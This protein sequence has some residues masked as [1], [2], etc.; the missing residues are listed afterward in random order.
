MFFF[1]S[2]CPLCK[3]KGQKVNSETM[4]H[5]VKDISKISDATYFY[6]STPSCDIVYFNNTEIFNTSMI[7]KEVGLKDSSSQQ[8]LV[9][10]CY[11]YAKSSL[12]TIGLSEKI[13]IRMNNYGSRCDTRHPA[14]ECCL[15]QIKQIVQEKLISKEKKKKSIRED[16]LR[17]KEKQALE[18]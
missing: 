11:N 17:L 2:K 12:D 16:M 5:H 13:E 3:Q 1:T 9:C 14:G 18:N 6:C 15:P 10:Y 4:L 8:A 7:N